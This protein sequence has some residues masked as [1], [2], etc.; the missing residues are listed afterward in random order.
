MDVFKC[1][2]LFPLMLVQLASE[3]E[4]YSF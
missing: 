1:F 4:V 3:H 2:V